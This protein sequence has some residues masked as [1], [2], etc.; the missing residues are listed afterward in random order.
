MDRITLSL[1][2]GAV[3]AGVALATCLIVYERRTTRARHPRNFRAGHA[4]AFKLRDYEVGGC[5]AGMDDERGRQL[6]DATLAALRHTV[7]REGHL[8][9]PSQNALRT[10]SRS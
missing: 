3:L 2:P 6:L 10:P 7:E 8:L 9:F 1:A 4:A 5:Y